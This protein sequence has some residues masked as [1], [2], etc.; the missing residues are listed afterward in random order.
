MSGFSYD[1]YCFSSLNAIA[2]ETT[3]KVSSSSQY[4]TLI[5]GYT[6]P[7][8]Y[9]VSYNY[10]L[11]NLSNGDVTNRI[12]DSI[13]FACP[14]IGPLTPSNIQELI[15]SYFLFDAAF[16]EQVQVEMLI[17]FALGLTVGA[18]V[19]LLQKT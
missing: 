11:F 8:T 7:N 15:E 18:V 2:I 4:V 12:V 14:D 5:N 3:G 6:I 9:T 1:G 10:R 13:Y 17:A 16:F 19:K